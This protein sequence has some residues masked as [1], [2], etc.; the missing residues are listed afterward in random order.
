MRTAWIIAAVF[1]VALPGSARDHA[2]RYW[3]VGHRGSVPERVSRDELS[4]VFL[5]K[6]RDWP[7]D[8]AAHPV[9]LP[10]SSAVR[11]EFSRDVLGRSLTAVRTYWAQQIFSGRDVPPPE[12][13]EAEALRY[14][15]STPGA[16]A[17]VSAGQPLDDV[18]VLQIE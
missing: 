12:L 3:V 5:K 4:D 16:V 10:P 9:D 8:G 18:V 15:R 11:E 2:T 7:A 6:V 17:Y 14:V 13:S 1:L